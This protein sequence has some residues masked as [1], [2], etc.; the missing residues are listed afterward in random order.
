[1]NMRFVQLKEYSP[2]GE[3]KYAFVNPHYV[4]S[5]KSEYNSALDIRL[6]IISINGNERATIITTE[7]IGDVMIKLDFDLNQ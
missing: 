1:M 4:A 5:V 7:S 6:V 3:L 2:D